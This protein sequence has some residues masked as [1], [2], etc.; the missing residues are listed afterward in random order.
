MKVLFIV[1]ELLYTCGVSTHIYNLISGFKK[2]STIELYLL[3]GGGV[4]ISKFEDIGIDVL[5]DENIKHENRS[6]RGYI[7]AILNL[8]QL[9]NK[10]EIDI[11]HSHHHY[12]ASIA[13]KSGIFK[14]VKTIQTNH[15][16]LPEIGFINHFSSN[17]II[18][19]NQHI[20]DYIIRNK[21]RPPQKVR[22]IRALGYI[23]TLN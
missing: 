11:I 16:I 19:V 18:G 4:A 10:Y 22:L 12:A 9:I 1:N 6:I 20:V 2:N 8:S 5:I 17:F 14:N 23:C 13:Q 15:G 3:C 7:K 21:I